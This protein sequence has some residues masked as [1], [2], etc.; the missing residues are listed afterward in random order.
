[1][2]AQKK[3][4][5]TKLRGAEVNCNGQYANA[6]PVAGNMRRGTPSPSHNM[7]SGRGS[8]LPDMEDSLLQQKH[9]AG[10]DEFAGFQP[11]E[12]KT[13]GRTTGVPLN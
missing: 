7:G 8:V 10:C 6:V 5:L 2:K 9:P 3:N 12:I 11:V 13:A 4:T 1:M